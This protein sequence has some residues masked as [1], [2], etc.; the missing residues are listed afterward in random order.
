MAEMHSMAYLGSTTRSLRGGREGGGGEELEEQGGGSRER[1][2]EDIGSSEEHRKPI[3]IPLCAS[4]DPNNGNHHRHWK[5]LLCLWLLCRGGLIRRD[6]S[7]G[8]GLHDG[9]LVDLQDV[10]QD[11]QTFV[12]A[13]G[14]DQEV[15][16]R[17][18]ELA[19]K[20]IC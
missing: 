9:L 12:A 3:H 20:E 5:I 1:D 17:Q 11:P 7:L 2:L 8:G 18:I 10:L 4:Q 19:R 13:V 16:W 14:D 15:G 6:G